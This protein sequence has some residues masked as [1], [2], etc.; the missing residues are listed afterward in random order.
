MQPE[1][2]YDRYVWCNMMIEK[3]SENKEIEQTSLKYRKSNE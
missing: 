2:W 3:S 1:I